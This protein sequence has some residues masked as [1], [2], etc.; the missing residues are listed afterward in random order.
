MPDILT[1]L[2]NLPQTSAPADEAVVAAD[3][4][5]GHR[6]VRR[7]RQQRIGFTAAAVAVVAGVAVGAGQLGTTG[8]HQPTT[9]AGTG[10]TAAG[11]QMVDY[12]GEQPSGFKVTTVPDGWTVISSQP[13]EFVVAP[14]GRETGVG[15]SA[16]PSSG[17]APVSYD[18]RIA[19]YMVGDGPGPS[20]SH[21]EK[22]DING[23]PGKLGAF[24]KTKTSPDAHWLT[25]PSDHGTVVVQVPD[26]TGLSNDQIL[27][28]ARGV[29]VTDA[30][31]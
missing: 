1:V 6:A 2:Q 26:S 16:G 24:P 22:V 29:T 10:V 8:N 20:G 14:P 7:R 23:K 15:P 12:T 27:T 17:P 18:G 4:A 31:R 13:D 30:V 28:F 11:M 3:V 5:R 21:P 25:F 19:V 9:A